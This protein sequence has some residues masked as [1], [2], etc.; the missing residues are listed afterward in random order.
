MEWIII[1]VIIAIFINLIINF[2]AVKLDCYYDMRKVSDKQIKNIQYAVM[3]IVTITLILGLDFFHTL[4]KKEDGPTLIELII[5]AIYILFAFFETK[6]I[7]LV[8][9]YQRKKKGEKIIYEEEIKPIIYNE[10]K[11]EDKIQKER[12]K[13]SKEKDKL[14]KEMDLY[15]LE[16]FEREE[17]RRGYYSPENFEEEDLED[18]DYY[19]EDD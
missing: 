19:F 4:F 7:K 10:D 18:D 5:L 14:E 15:N 9:V 13:K 1:F 11:K 8:Y 12:K 3:V 2:I 6:I 17:V 16:E